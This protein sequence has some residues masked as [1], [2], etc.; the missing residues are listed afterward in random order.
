MYSRSH[1]SHKKGFF[2]MNLFCSKYKKKEKRKKVD[3][4]NFIYFLIL[5]SSLATLELCSSWLPLR[6]SE[7]NLEGYRR[8]GL[9]FYSLFPIQKKIKNK[10][11]YPIYST[12][13]FLYTEL[14][15]CQWRESRSVFAVRYT[16]HGHWRSCAI[17]KMGLHLPNAFRI[18]LESR[19]ES[20]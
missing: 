16:K 2:Y 18:C 15:L 3:N 9:W 11:R 6:P 17:Q 5:I 20:K 7:L 19:V 8:V 4:R 13:K 14:L 1:Y 12:I 10:N